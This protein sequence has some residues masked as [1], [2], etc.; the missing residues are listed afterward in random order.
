[1]KKRGF[2]NS[3]AIQNV[4]FDRDLRIYNAKIDNGAQLVVYSHHNWE[5]MTWQM[6][7]V[8]DNTFLLKN[9]YTQKSFQPETQPVPNT[10]LQQQ[11]LGGS[12]L[13]YWEFLPKIDKTYSIRL[14]DTDLYLTVISNTNNAE[15]VLM[16]KMDTNNQIWRLIRQNPII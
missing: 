4:A 16:P 2:E 1:M 7:E 11:T 10:A 9:L 8:S 6:I 14:K 13:Q 5:C 12:S 15:V 3:Y